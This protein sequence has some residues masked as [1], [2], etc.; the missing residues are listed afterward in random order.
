MSDELT[1]LPSVAPEGEVFSADTVAAAKEAAKVAQQ[2]FSEEEGAEAS[3]VDGDTELDLD[4]TLPEASDEEPVA[5]A[6]TTSETTKSKVSRL[7]KEREK[8][9]QVRQ[10]IESKAKA[11]F[12]QAN[13]LKQQYE[14]G[15]RQLQEQAQWLQQLKQNPM[16]ALSKAGY[17]PQEL[18]ARM[19]LEGTPEGE[20]IKSQDRASR[21]L[22]EL[23]QWKDQFEQNLQ[24]QQEEFK[25]QQEQTRRQNILSSYTS[26]ATNAEKYP[27]LNDLYADDQHILVEMGHRVADLYRSATGKNPTREQICEYLE[28]R[29]AEK[30]Q[31]LAQ[32]VSGKSGKP[33]GVK[34]KLPTSV[35]SKQLTER[36]TVKPEGDSFEDRYAAAKAVESKLFRRSVTVLDED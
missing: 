7:L 3:D 29:A 19:A 32:K 23:R 26:E 36:A 28:E 11:Q 15:L 9:Y 17:T 18:A 34:G 12:D 5:A 33:Q 35:S 1:S 25:V 20:A 24:K 13:Q 27:N 4:H 14:Q 2:A 8:A 30:A 16:E 31:K 22:Q 6:P 10:E 21:E